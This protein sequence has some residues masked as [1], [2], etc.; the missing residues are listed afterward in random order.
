MHLESGEWRCRG[1]VFDLSAQGAL[2][3]SPRPLPPG[4]RLRVDVHS[5]RGIITLHATVVRCEAHSAPPYRSALA[6]AECAPAN[7]AT[8]IEVLDHERSVRTVPRPSVVQGAPGRP[9]IVASYRSLLAAALQGRPELSGAALLRHARS[10]GYQGGKTALYE[11][12]AR[13]RPPRRIHQL[14]A[15][16]GGV[17]CVAVHGVRIAP[18][19][20]RGAREAPVAVLLGVLLYSGWVVASVAARARPGEVTAALRAQLETLGGPPLHLHVERPG[21]LARK[22]A[23]A[24]ELAE[25]GAT[26]GFSTDLRA[27][28]GAPPREAR[29]LT[30]LVREVETSGPMQDRFALERALTEACSRM[31]RTVSP[32]RL[33]IDRRA[34]RGV[35]RTA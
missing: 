10:A 28:A 2:V 3:L 5:G 35:T 32:E 13:L 11:E 7:R 8:L 18:G 20:R 12:I 15:L 34:L 4:A 31:N 23:C 6:F 26:L 30:C 19:P 24:A 25:L 1:R 14:A 33:A 29:A 9:S 27:R 22:G 21:C 17:Y 16:P